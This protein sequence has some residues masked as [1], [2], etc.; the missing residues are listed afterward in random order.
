VMSASRKLHVF[1]QSSDLQ[2]SKVAHHRLEYPS[3]Y[4]S[5]REQGQME[6]GDVRRATVTTL[7]SAELLCAYKIVLD[8]VQAT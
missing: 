8:R 1:Y 7:Q 4:S 5:A 6:Q 3:R 2:G